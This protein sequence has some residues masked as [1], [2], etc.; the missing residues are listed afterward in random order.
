MEIIIK[1]KKC[2]IDKEDLNKYS[3]SHWHVS[4]GYLFVSRKIKDKWV[5]VPISRLIMNAPEN[6]EVDHINRNK[7]DNRKENLRLATTSQNH[8]NKPKQSNN[9]S[10]YKGIHWRKNRN[11]WIATIQVNKNRKYLGCSSDIKEVVKIYNEAAKSYFG[12]YAYLN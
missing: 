7:L 8:A 11:K 12:N 6:L 5:N 2:L 10:G 9:T 1:N 4:K 3:G